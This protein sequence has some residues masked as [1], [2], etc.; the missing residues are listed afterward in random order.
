MTSEKANYEKELEE[1]KK[2]LLEEKEQHTRTKIKLLATK[3]ELHS[4]T[5][6]K[7]YKLA[8]SIAYT[9]HIVK[10]V[11]DQTFALTPKRYKLINDNRKLVRRAYES[12]DFNNDFSIEP[13]AKLAVVL[14]LYY[15][16]LLGYFVEKLKNI[17]NL[18]Y[19]LFVTIPTTKKE[20]IASVKKA[21]PNARISVVPN[22]GRDVLP[23]VEVI[24]RINELG[25]TKV[26]KLH[27][28]KS[29]HR[30]DGDAWRDQIV[31][32]L[33]PEDQSVQSEIQRT[34][35]KRNTAIIGPAGQYLS[36]IKNLQENYFQI[37]TSM[38]SLLVLCSGYVWMRYCQ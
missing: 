33:L 3:R 25:Y 18:K 5:T 27:S 34:L 36:L 15:P 19:D 28:K 8:K 38:V 14:H 31:G 12:N 21:L 20:S 10:V 11:R 6:S 32:N 22:C 7:S 4:I 37:L 29:P 9:K 24:K 26:L 30:E 23:F 17:G 1:Y 13:T 16:E 2:L 35:N